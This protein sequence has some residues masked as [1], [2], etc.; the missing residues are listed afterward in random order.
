M[1]KN[2]AI[3]VPAV[4]AITNRD[5][6]RG[7]L[8]TTKVRLCVHGRLPPLYMHLDEIGNVSSANGVNVSPLCMVEMDTTS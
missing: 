6:K 2:M 3:A 7:L 1:L 4:A 5:G 8:D